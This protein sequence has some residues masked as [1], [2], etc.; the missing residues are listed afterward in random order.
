MNRTVLILLSVTLAGCV[1]QTTSPAPSLSAADIVPSNYKEW[2]VDAMFSRLKDPYSIRSSEISAP[3]MGFIG[4]LR[5]VSGAVVCV[6]YN[7]KNSFGAYTGISSSAFIFADGRLADAI[8]DNPIA[9]N[10]AIYMP[11]PELE[12][13]HRGVSAPLAA[14]KA[15]TA[16]RGTLLG[17]NLG[18]MT[19]ATMAKV[20]MDRMTGLYVVGVDPGRPAATAGIRAGDVILSLDGTAV[21]SLSDISATTAK[22]SRGQ[23]VPAVIWRDGAEETMQVTF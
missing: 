23:I 6:R 5:G 1:A 13:V 4:L 14:S 12:A 10:N 9:C 16:A 22:L 20:K 3:D 8:W 21:S 19:P 17:V 11:F 2:I 15:E 7:A 18:L